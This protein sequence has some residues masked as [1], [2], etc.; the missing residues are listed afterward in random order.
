[1]SQLTEFHVIYCLRGKYG[2]HKG[3]W[4]ANMIVSTGGIIVNSP[5]WSDLD[6]NP[7][8]HRFHPLFSE[9]E[10]DAYRFMNL[11]AAEIWQRILGGRGIDTEIIPVKPAPKALTKTKLP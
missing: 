5:N 11:S 6:R 10:A 9:S 3:L 1:M 7:V 2:D 8:R 4:V